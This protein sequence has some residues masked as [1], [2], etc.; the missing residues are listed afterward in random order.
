MTIIIHVLRQGQRELALA[1]IQYAHPQKINE[2]EEGQT[3]LHI[4]IQKNFLDI[5]KSL[6]ERKANIDAL[7]SDPSYSKMTPLHYAALIGNLP[8]TRLLLAWG[9][10]TNQKNCYGQTAA[11]LARQHGFMDVANLIEHQ[12]QYSFQ[13]PDPIKDR[14]YSLPLPNMIDLQT[15][16]LQITGW[17]S[18]KNKPVTNIIDFAAYKKKRQHKKR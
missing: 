4:A 9:A 8:A 15:N 11:I 1:L 2:Y 13:C 14:A 18:K 7:G 6:L 3:A 17:F 5:A 12:Q 16:T 10:K